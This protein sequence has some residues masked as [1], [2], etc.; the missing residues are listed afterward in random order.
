[1]PQ[2]KVALA[3]NGPFADI[4]AKALLETKSFDVVVVGRKEKDTVAGASTKIVPAWDVPGLTEAFAG[5][6]YVIS[7]L[8]MFSLAD[9]QFVVIHAAKAAG[10]KGIVLSEYGVPV[11]AYPK[12]M[13]GGLK[14]PARELVKQVGLDWIAL[15]NGFFLDYPFSAFSPDDAT[16]KALV[17]GS[18]E[19]KVSLASREDVAAYLAQVVLRFD[20]FKSGEVQVSAAT[21]SV[22]EV[23]AE[24]GKAKGIT[25]EIVSEPVGEAVPKFLANTQDVFRL[26]GIAAAQGFAL[27]D[28]DVTAKFPSVHPKGLD[29]WIPKLYGKQE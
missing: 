25:Y 24:I 16:K 6:D 29:Y 26:I 23:I 14:V 18:P 5:V 21:V 4:V 9:P 7:T 2:L 8:G 12:S 22:R 3:G 17:I 10:V 15:I 20:E 13:L 19:A 28:N 27:N 1:M 11:T